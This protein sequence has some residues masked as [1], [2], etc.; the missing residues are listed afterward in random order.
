M[1]YINEIKKRRSV[2]TFDNNKNITNDTLNEIKEFINKLSN[3]FNIKIEWFILNKEEYK[4]SSPVIANEKYYIAGKL[5]KV[6]NGELAFGYEY[7][8]LALYLE[9]IGLGTTCMAGTLPRP[10]FESAIN[11]SDDEMMPC[12]TPIGYPSEKMSLKEKIM[13]KGLKADSRLDFDSLFYSKDFNKLDDL[14]LNKYKD[15]LELVRIAPSAVN[16]QPWRLIIDNNKIYFYKYSKK[17]LMTKDGIDIKNVDIG[18]ALNHFIEG[19]SSKNMK[20]ELEFSNPNINKED[21]E[22][23]VTLIINE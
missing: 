5:K 4:L 6:E 14:E 13:R 23:I 7:E 21:F 20:Y 17:E 9:S 11:L 16:K 1:N 15:I 3:P 22:Y 2:R 12:V 19:L 18:I 10:K 8:T